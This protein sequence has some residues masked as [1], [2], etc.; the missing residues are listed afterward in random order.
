MNTKYTVTNLDGNTDSNNINNN[1]P[2]LVTPIVFFSN[3]FQ[4]WNNLI[5]LRVSKE[6]SAK[7][8]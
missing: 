6:V 8:V 1:S 2:H 4:N 3:L 5:F 7:L